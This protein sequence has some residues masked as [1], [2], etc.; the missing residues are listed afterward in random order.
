MATAG[1]FRTGPATFTLG[2]TDWVP[3]PTPEQLDQRRQ[4]MAEAE[5]LAGWY[6][7]ALCDGQD[8]AGNP[9]AWYE[10]EHLDGRRATVS[11]SGSSTDPEL[12]RLLAERRRA[13]PPPRPESPWLLSPLRV[14]RA[15]SSWLAA[16]RAKGR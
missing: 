5:G 13:Q 6:T 16:G 9:I 1:R 4:R 8:D 2:D 7:S 3:Q 15:L 11:E 10:Y 14:I 12:Q